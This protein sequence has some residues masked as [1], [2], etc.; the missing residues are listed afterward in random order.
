ML[1][2]LQKEKNSGME[3]KQASK[4]RWQN[5]C[6]S[7]ETHQPTNSRTSEN[8]K[9]DKYKTPTPRHPGVKLLSTDKDK[10]PQP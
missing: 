8:S 6:R 5:C 3:Q 2:E 1:F 7:H 4:K 9:E 10:H